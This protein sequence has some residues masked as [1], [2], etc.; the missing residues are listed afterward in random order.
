M[1]YR[2]FWLG[3][4]HGAEFHFDLGAF[5]HRYSGVLGAIRSTSGPIQEVHYDSVG[6]RVLDLVSAACHGLALDH[7]VLDHF[8][9][10]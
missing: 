3:F 4:I 5:R 8:Q 2:P 9:L 7:S 6:E 10:D 1:V